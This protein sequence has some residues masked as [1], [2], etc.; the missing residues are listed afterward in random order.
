[1]KPWVKILI[2][3]AALA[4]CVAGCFIVVDIVKN[5][6][7]KPE[8]GTDTVTV[9]GFDSD[10][11]SFS[12]TYQDSSAEFEL[13]NYS[14][15][16]T[17]DGDMP[18]KQEALDALA[19]IIRDGAK[20]VRL[21]DDTGSLVKSESFGLDD[22]AITVRASDGTV[23]KTLYIGNFNSAFDAYYANVEG[24]GEV[25]LI[26]PEVPESFM[27]DIFALAVDAE[28]FPEISYE[29]VVRIRIFDGDASREMTYSEGGSEELYSD[30]Y[31]WFEQ[32][33]SGEYT[34]LRTSAMTVLSEETVSF[35]DIACVAYASDS[36]TL[37]AY[38]LDGEPRGFEIS[39]IGE[40]EVEN[41]VGIETQEAELSLE[42]RISPADEEGNCYMTWSDNPT[43]YRVSSEKAEAVMGALE[44][45]LTPDEVCAISLDSVESFNV[46]Y[47]GAEIN[48]VKTQTSIAGAEGAEDA[49]TNIF[50]ANGIVVDATSVNSF[51]DGLLALTVEDRAEEGSWD[52]NAEPHMT[53]SFSRNTESFPEMTMYVYEYNVNFYRI[54]FNGVDDMLV[55]IRNIDNMGDAILRTLK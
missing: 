28:P 12:Y 51:Y 18:L 16:N 33:S 4:V 47:N 46:L 36:E 40:I 54:S 29:D 26:S 13:V 25:H 39:Y 8:E 22:P 6:E 43:V 21:V 23:A 7:E 19:K 53:V 5:S 20:S 37:A 52:E 42:V 11:Q 9:G 27:M 15:V 35:D 41:A 10:V 31:T 45:D 55:S 1:M 14:W 34:A 49:V 48:V 3:V 32:T 24:S 50:T 2:L 17:A 30:Y 38:G 44:A